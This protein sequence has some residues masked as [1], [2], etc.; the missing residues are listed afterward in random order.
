[1]EETFEI[2]CPK[3]GSTQITANKKGY[4]AG[5]AVTG[6]ILTGGVGLLAGFHGSGK[7]L[8]TCLACGKEFKAGEGKK[9]Y[10]AK[11]ISN[12][13]KTN[14]VPSDRIG[15]N[16]IVCSECETVNFTNHI[17]CRNCGRVLT[18]EDTWISSIERLNVT[19]C[20]S[21]KQLTP[22][23]GNYCTHCKAETKGN[24]NN[25]NTGCM[26]VLVIGL[27]IS[28]ITTLMSLL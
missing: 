12:I 21:C 16:R 5:K 23:V 11:L 14:T 2:G 22:I 6:A 24:T 28:G 7:V 15:L 3:C 19:T 13:T 26:A 18:K 20:R 10:P 9:I 17:Y 8:I 25:T 27:F 4:S 1:M